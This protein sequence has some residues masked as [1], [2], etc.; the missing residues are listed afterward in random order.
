M[1]GNSGRPLIHFL[2]VP[3]S[4]NLE[5]PLLLEGVSINTSIYNYAPTHLMRIL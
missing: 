1:Q 2:V 4:L 5:H 3:R